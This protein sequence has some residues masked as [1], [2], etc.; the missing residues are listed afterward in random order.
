MNKQIHALIMCGG[1]GTRLAPLTTETPKQFLALADKKLTMIQLTAERIKPLVQENITVV[2]NPKQSKWVK[3]QLPS[4]TIVLE[5]EA[6]N[7]APAIGL[8]ALYMQ[9]DDIMLVFPAF[10]S[11]TNKISIF[12]I[13][14][15]ISFNIK[16]L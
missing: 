12:S 9:P 13:S 1:S 3:E 5:P 15:S 8:A 4:A 6:R 10:G 16:I 7:T 2:T 14:S 11:P